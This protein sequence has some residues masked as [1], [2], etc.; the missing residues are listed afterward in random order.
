MRTADQL[1]HSRTRV[2]SRY[3]L[4]PLEGFPVSRLPDWTLT[5]ARILAA[6]ALGARFAQYLLDLQPE[7]GLRRAPDRRIESFIYVLSG[8]VNVNAGQGDNALTEGGFAFIPHTSPH[9]L[10]AT[11]ASRLLMLRKEFEPAAGIAPPGPVFGNQSQVRAE[12]YLGNE[13]ARLQTLL[14]DEQAYDMAMNIFT[15]DPGHCLPYVETHVME[16]GL[17][18]LEGK[19]VYYLGED[20]MEVQRDD[21][22]WMGPYCPQSFYATGPTPSRYIYYKNVNREIPL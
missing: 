17:Y 22:I 10:C 16:H 18:F 2:R 14:P 19:G 11:A 7:G 9:S 15:F 8:Q 21:F 20:W 1:L 4:L 13:H 3:A 12:T 6:P 5:E